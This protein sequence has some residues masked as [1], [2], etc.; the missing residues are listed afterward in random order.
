MTKPKW[1][2][3]AYTHMQF[4]LRACERR[5]HFAANPCQLGAAAR[6]CVLG[7][8]ALAG[9]PAWRTR[10]APATSLVPLPPSLRR[11]PVTDITALLKCINL[12]FFAGAFAV[13]S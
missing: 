6:S 3:H 13:Y 9:V 7:F 1:S 12:F 8:H 10:A 5:D 4:Y 2:Q 11:R